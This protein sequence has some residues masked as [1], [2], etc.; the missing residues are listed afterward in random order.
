M[1]T[2]IVKIRVKGDYMLENL[3][4]KLDTIIP[5]TILFVSVFYVASKNL[6]PTF[7]DYFLFTFLALEFLLNLIAS[8]LERKGINNHWVYHLN[9]F[10]TQG[11]FS[12]YFSRVLMKS[13]MVYLTYL[14]F[15]IFYF[16][17]LLWAQK[18]NQF[19]SY[20]YAFGSFLIVLYTFFN[21]EQLIDQ[22]PSESLFYLKDFWLLT[23]ALTY[24]G[25]C[26]LI[27]VSYNYLS[28]VSPE[29]VGIL[30]R[31]HNLFFTFSCIIF[32]KSIMS[33]QWIA[34]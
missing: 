13:R 4:L 6:K 29:N 30:W 14:I 1:V 17:V 34:K 28:E 26:F 22:M 21:F 2:S 27:F 18:Y 20:S 5:L 32:M 31:I 9:C 10:V 16:I 15:I 33:K 3:L 8:M 24:F 25:S 11:I 7:P 23:G 19:P 12:Y